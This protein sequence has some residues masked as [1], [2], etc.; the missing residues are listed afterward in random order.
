MPLLETR[1]LVKHYHLGKQVVRALNGVSL[2]VESGE[3]VAVMGPS[4]SGKTTLLSLIGCLD[5]PTSGTV[6]LNGTDVS[7]LAEKDLPRIRRSHIGFVFQHFN[8]IPTLTALENVMLPLKYS[9][10]PRGEA[11]SCAKEILEGVGMYERVSHRPSELSGGEQQRVAIARALVRRPVLV[12]ADEPTGELDTDTGLQ[13]IEL[14]KQFNQT[15]GNT[16]IVVTHDALLAQKA[17][18]IIR[19]KDGMIEVENDASGGIV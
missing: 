5:S 2:K 10:M 9:H 8:L 14:M 3:F 1:D 4:G 6:L 11:V 12:L 15:L 13:I 7:R 19:L 17:G 18:R 16:F